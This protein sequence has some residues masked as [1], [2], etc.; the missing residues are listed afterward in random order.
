MRDKNLNFSQFNIQLEKNCRKWTN[1]PF[2]QFFASYVLATPTLQNKSDYK[3]NYPKNFRLMR[4]LC[5]LLWYF[6]EESKWSVWLDLK[7]MSFS[8]FNRKQKLEIQILLMSKEIMVQYLYRTNRYTSNELFGNFLGND[9]KEL[10]KTL[11][12]FEVKTQVKRTVRRRGYKDH[13]S[14][15]PDEKWLPDSDCSF[16][17]YQNEKER[18]QYLFNS[19]LSRLRKILEKFQ[20]QKKEENEERN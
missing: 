10:F 6:P 16:N 2:H 12:A 9:A 18:K 11:K 8:H 19:T 1:H 3:V 13:G 14:R 4:S 15:K 5:I 17:E 20:K 7:G